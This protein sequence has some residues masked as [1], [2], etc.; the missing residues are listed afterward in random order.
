[1]AGG[2]WKPKHKSKPG[3][4]KPH[5]SR[6]TVSIPGPPGIDLPLHKQRVKSIGQN[7]SAVGRQPLTKKN[8]ELKKASLHTEWQQL[9][10]EGGKANPQ[11]S[12]DL[13]RISRL[14]DIESIGGEERVRQLLTRGE[15]ARATRDVSCLWR[16][17]KVSDRGALVV[18]VCKK[19][20]AKVA[21]RFS[22][23]VVYATNSY[24]VSHKLILPTSSLVGHT[25]IASCITDGADRSNPRRVGTTYL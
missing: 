20:R 5:V 2:V 22:R 15:L 7:P 17:R 14:L 11:F 12:G 13:S 4:M 19:Y 24:R 16:W 1:M 3:E 25:A 21:E 9:Q 23:K 6:E 18:D 8:R 10:T